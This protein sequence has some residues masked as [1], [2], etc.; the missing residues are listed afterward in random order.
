VP[1]PNGPY[2]GGTV[3][4]V[5]AQPQNYTVV[6]GST[7][8]FTVQAAGSPPLAYQWFHGAELISGATAA[9]LQ[10]AGATPADAGAYSVVVY[11]GAGYVLSSNAT[12]TVLV[13]ASITRQ[14]ADVIMKG[15]NAPGI[16]GYTFSNATF[17]VQATSSTTMTY[18]WRR[19]GAPIPAATS[20]TLVIQNVTL[21]NVGSYDCVIT[22]AVGPITTQ[23]AQLIVNVPVVI[24]QHPQSQVALVGD[25]V[26][27]R[28]YTTGTEPFFYRW[29]RNGVAVT[30]Q[31]N[32]SVYTLANVQTNLSGQFSVVVTNAGFF[33]PGALSAIAFLT[34]LEDRDGDR[35]PDVWETD[36]G[37]N[38]DNPS[39]G[40][41]DADGDHML[42]KDEFFAG[43]NPRDPQSYLKVEFD[44]A[45]GNTLQFMAI[46]NRSYSVQFIDNLAT[47]TWSNLTHAFSRT[48]NRLEQVADPSGGSKRFYRLVTPLQE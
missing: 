27:F 20:S 4:T 25:T 42:N 3:P 33:Q 10:L 47:G 23:P 6:A 32:S 31:P 12:L 44:P 28:V 14:P 7:A 9:T 40:V 24:T 8:T 16:Y 26:S 13:P 21:A 45:G 19:N 48:T 15:S 1:T 46:S 36:N 5:V 34:V 2:P 35:A 38:P 22:D 41:G 29:R 11:N 43:T 39:D 30:P 37:F 17:T 18:Q